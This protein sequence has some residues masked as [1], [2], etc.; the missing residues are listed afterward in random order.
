LAVDFPGAVARALANNHALVAAGFEW[1]AAAREADI[2]RGLYL[3]SLTFEE[4]FIRT[5]VPAEVFAH[6]IDQE[7]LAASDFASVDTFNKPSP[8]NDFMTVFT[9]EQTL[10]APKV[11]L[12]SRMAVREAEAKG[13]DFERAKEEAVFRVLAAYLEVLSAKES[14]RT[15]DKAVADVRE[16]VRIAKAR[17][18]SGTG[19]ASDVLRAGVSLA[20]AESRLVTEESRLAL[21][22]RGLAL[23]MGEKEE[24]E[25]D[26]AGPLP[27]LPDD[28]TIEGRV[29]SALSRRRDL[30]AAALRAENAATEVSYRKSEYLPTLGVT[31]KYRFDGQ[32]GP[33]SPDN[34]SWNVGVGLS[35]TLFDG[36]RREA[37]VARARALRER[38]KADY[39]GARGEAAFQVA[40]AYLAVQEAGRRRE[41][42]RA[43][44]A[45]AEEGTRLIRSRYENQLARMVDLLDA[46]TALDAARSELVRS[47]NDLSRSRAELLFRSGSLLPWALPGTEEKR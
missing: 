21:A 43:S 31:G 3:P 23:A 25:A 30:G 7:R 24:T 20:S 44:I 34:R 36:Y 6:K 37:S 17:E 18:S 40:R 2:A 26:A 13:L 46:Q 4:R 42:A 39:E 45:A 16:H 27:P 29:T 12:G 8:I 11:H 41:I 22:R 14:V 32:D 5:N 19:L 15:A 28:G 9:L 33:F 38:A 35:W 1:K 47:E 10:F